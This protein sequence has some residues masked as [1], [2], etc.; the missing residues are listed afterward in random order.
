M[1]K[2]CGG[3]YRSREQATMRVARPKKHANRMLVFVYEFITGGG[4]WTLGSDPPAGS[5][6]AEGRAMAAAVIADFAA[7]AGCEVVTLRDARLPPLPLSALNSPARIERVD[8]AAAEQSLLDHWASRADWTLVVAPEFQNMLLCRAERVVAAGGRLLSPGPALIELAANKQATAEHLQRHGIRVPA[9]CLW[10]T[11]D[12]SRGVLYAPPSDFQFPAVWKPLDGCGSLDVELIADQT[13]L[14]AREWSIDGRLET[15]CPG[16]AASVSLLAGPAGV[17]ALPACQQ[18]LS[19]DGRFTY[20]GGRLPLAPELA[21][22]AQSL[23]LAAYQTLPAPHGYLGI[24]LVLGE[25]ASGE[26]DYVIEIN[27]RLTTSYVGLRRLAHENLAGAMF[28]ARAGLSPALSWHAHALE[29][30]AAGD[31][32]IDSNRQPQEARSLS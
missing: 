2:L 21:A 27:P 10:P 13:E 11:R 23:A 8:S 4:M 14:I 31:V 7:L 19:A 3:L 15:F 6:L 29:F 16:I 25:V 26:L 28:A 22:R 17:T 9:G 30:S 24:D 12:Q 5:L 1:R 20:L 32:R 18:I